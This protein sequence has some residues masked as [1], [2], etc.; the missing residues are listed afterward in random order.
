M[1]SYSYSSLNLFEQCPK[2]FEYKY[3][4]NE[5]EEFSTIEQH[6][7]K[8]VHSILQKVYSEKAKSNPMNESSIQ[9][10][11][12]DQWNS[13][14]LNK[15]RIIKRGCPPSTYYLEGLSM[16]KSYHSRIYLQDDSESLQL[17]NRFTMTLKAEGRTYGYSG[18]I[19]RLS[20]QR[21]GR[22]MLTDY[23][24]GKSVRNPSE[25]LQLRSYSLFVFSTNDVDEIELCYE[26]L[27]S[28]LSLKSSLSRKQ[29]QNILDPLVE[30]IELIESAV[31]YP[32]KP[33]I[34]CDWCGFNEECSARMQRGSYARS[35]N[36]VDDSDEE[37][38]DL[39]DA[40][41]RCGAELKER[42]GRRGT[43][44]GC[45]RFPNCRYTRDNW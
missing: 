9:R 8:T 40:C 33:S 3:I 29:I 10:F 19:D 32:A 21:T 1:E 28:G 43:F 35:W 23:K 17:E 34:L 38:S 39:G 14:E 4:K 45:S 24:T 20:K 36:S 18:V 37:D 41:P 25:D 6:L 22:L 44:I 12:D 16:V 5:D 11:Y 7:G 31:S 13:Q 42:E 15:V 26:D 30:K 2:A 27:R